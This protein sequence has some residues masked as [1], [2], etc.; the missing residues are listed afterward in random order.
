MVF[1][2]EVSCRVGILQALLRVR[3]EAGKRGV[4]QA[5]SPTSTPDTLGRSGS[6]DPHQLHGRKKK[7]VQGQKEHD[8]AKGQRAGDTEQR[9]VT[10][11]SA[12]ATRQGGLR[13]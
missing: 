12:G 6:D 7:K 10:L 3:K 1:A 2:G 9:A 8:P 11:P 13:E 5:G 4:G